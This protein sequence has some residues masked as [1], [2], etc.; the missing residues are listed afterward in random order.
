MRRWFR[1]GLKVTSSEKVD[2]FGRYSKFKLVA[3]PYPGV[4]FFQEFKANNYS[5]RKLCF[6]W[7]QT[8]ADAELQLPPGL[9]DNLGIRWGDYKCWDLG[10]CL[11][12]DYDE[13]EAGCW[14]RMCL[15]SENWIKLTVIFVCALFVVRPTRFVLQSS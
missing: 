15:L 7:S 6:N 8:F 12:R 14:L 5:A 3:T 9:S 13:R 4:E 11:G 1:Y 2:S 10:M